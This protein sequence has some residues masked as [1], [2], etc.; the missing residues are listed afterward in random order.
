MFKIVANSKGVK[1]SIDQQTF[2]L[3]IEHDLEM[4][5]LQRNKWY[6]RQLRIA[7]KRLQQGK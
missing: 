1:F 2:T 7:L 3:H 6:A 5:R 4:T